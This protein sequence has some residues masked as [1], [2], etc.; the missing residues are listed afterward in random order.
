MVI[1]FNYKGNEI[2]I[3]ALDNEWICNRINNNKTFYELDLLEYIKSRFT[4]GVGL[5]I[6]ANIGNHSIFFSKFIFDKTYAFE[7]NPTNFS[8]LEENKKIN[9]IDDKLII[10][11]VALSD[12]NYNY[13]NKDFKSNMGRSFIVEGDGNLLTKR[14]DEFD[15][16]K[17]DFIKMDVEGHELK[18]LKG[19]VNLINKD[20][21]HIVLECN[22]YTDDFEKLN[23]YMISIGYVCKKVIDNMFYYEHENISK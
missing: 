18:V 2:K 22:N 10:Y 13:V 9:N 17:V 7:T 19:A 1:K 6:G 21:P 16:P 8:L 11:N 23:P 5:D 12:S 14:L 20:Y 15:L 3:S 4:G